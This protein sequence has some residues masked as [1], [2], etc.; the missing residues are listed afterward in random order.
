MAIST[1][2]GTPAL[3]ELHTDLRRRMDQAVATFQARWP[4]ARL[5]ED[6]RQTEPFATEVVSRMRGTISRPLSLVLKGSPFQTK[7]WEGC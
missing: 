6:S 4:E 3:K 7:V 1:M 5:V 2:A